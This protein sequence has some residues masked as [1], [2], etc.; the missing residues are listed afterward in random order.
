MVVTYYKDNKINLPRTLWSYTKWA[1]KNKQWPRV[2]IYS[3]VDN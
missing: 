1:V 3:T 2:T